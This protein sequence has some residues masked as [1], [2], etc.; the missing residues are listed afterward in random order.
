[1]AA[2]KFREVPGRNGVMKV[3]TKADRNYYTVEDVMELLGVKQ[4]KA[5]S[6]IRSLRKELIASGELLEEYPVGRVP[7]KHFDSRC[8][9]L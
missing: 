3:F 1:M 6:I 5:Y 9:I 7:K 2:R 8:G 4:S